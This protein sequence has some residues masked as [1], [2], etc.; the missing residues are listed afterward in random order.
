[1]CFL[2]EDKYQSDR[3]L[4]MLFTLCVECASEASHGMLFQTSLVDFFYQEI[5][6]F[7]RRESRNITQKAEIQIR[8]V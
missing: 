2:W 1:M 7:D 4:M 8:A 3:L 5:I 6:I